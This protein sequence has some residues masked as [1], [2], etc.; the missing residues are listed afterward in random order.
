MSLASG[1]EQPHAASLLAAESGD[2]GMPEASTQSTTASTPLFQVGRVQY[3]CPA[4]LGC[5]AAAS[6]VLILVME[7][8]A[9]GMPIQLLYLDLNDPTRAADATVPGVQTLEHVRIFAHPSA[10]H[11]L[12]CTDTHTWYWTPS[13]PHARLLPRLQGVPITA[14]AWT[15]SPTLPT[16][17]AFLAGTARGDVIEVHLHISTPPAR[18]DLLDRWAR[19]SAGAHDAPLE[20]GIYRLFTLDDTHPITGIA[21]E[22]QGP[23]TLIVMATAT[24]LYEF[25]GPTQPFSESA[26]HWDPIFALY[27]GTALPHVK[28]ELPPGPASLATAIPPPHLPHAPTR[29]LSWLT[30]TGVYDAT[31]DAAHGVE[32]ADVLPYPTDEDTSPLYVGRTPLH[33]VLVYSDALVCLDALSHEEVYRT[34]L[35]LQA[36]ERVRGVAMDPATGTCWLYTSQSLFE[37]VVEKESRHTWQWLLTQHEYEAALA[38]CHDEPSRAHVYAAQ[39]QAYLAK[40]DAMAAVTCFLKAHAPSFEQVTVSLIEAQAW[41]ALRTYVLKRLDDTPV[42][43]NVSRLM[44]ATWLLELYLRA[45]DAEDTTSA[46]YNALHAE[47]THVLQTYASALDPSTTYALLA[48]QGRMDLWTTFAQ[49]Q[50]NTQ[51]VVERWIQAG[52][53]ERALE[54]LSAQSDPDLYYEFAAVLMRHAPQATVTYW[55]RC[56][57][58]DVARLLPALLQHRPLPK[59]PDYA[60]EYLRYTIDECGSMDRTAHAMRLTRLVE[61][62]ND[63]AALLTFVERASPE[64]LDLSLALRTCV[65]AQCQE[66]CVRLYARME[67][68]ELAVHLALEANDVDLAC[69]CADLVT[70]DEALRRELWLQCA[71]HAIQAKPHMHEAMQFLRRTDLL[72]VEDILPLFPDFTVIDDFKAE[73][74]ATLE[75]YVA[76]IDTLKEK[77]DNTTAT[78]ASIQADIQQ[79]SNRAIDID[80]EQPCMECSTPL[81][82]RSMYV[83]GCR[84]G[85]HADCLTTKVT[86]HLPPRRLRR[87]LQLQDELGT[88]TSQRQ[89]AQ[90]Q[91]TPTKSTTASKLPLGAS[92]ERM[93]EHVR[94]Q[95]IVDAITAS[96]HASVDT[97][98]RVWMQQAPVMK[99]TQSATEVTSRPATSD[100]YA[101][102]DAVRNEMNTIV[103]GTCPVCAWSVQQVGK[104]FTDEHQD[105]DDTDWLL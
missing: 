105:N 104:P 22:T 7:P 19:K 82:Q 100:T 4:P 21:L 14:V 101:Q 69:A 62:P 32:H 102:L 29:V 30:G 96:W 40:G 87:L 37:L 59:E 35:P 24:R 25:L 6:N 81:L 89:E 67:Q 51:Q 73:I 61:R 88:L 56:T 92:L 99:E 50:R 15:T 91:S 86:Q 98:R 54:A 46:T 95:A 48:R 74:C 47:A 42:T 64:A 31:M 97:S 33:I 90:T 43:A 9:D 63:R 53:W 2:M 36:K 58:L 77:M 39:G 26:P 23:H 27:R 44:L 18:R 76:K 80:T 65:Q 52:K 78:A 75:E 79:L 85:F 60:L 8:A 49:T 28:T 72:T 16:M 10:Q 103:A 38:F 83:F 34:S 41:E 13:W 1:Y 12:V 5:V 71:Q 57:S 66:A 94:P 11:I 70:Q 55:K 20:R 93:R 45:M 68:F 17:P 84:H 3:A